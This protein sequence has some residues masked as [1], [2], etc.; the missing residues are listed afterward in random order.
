M[1]GLSHPLRQYLK[2]PDSSGAFFGA[3]LPPPRLHPDS[4]PDSNPAPPLPHPSTGPQ[5]CEPPAGS[6]T[7][8]ERR[9]DLPWQE[10][11]P[12]SIIG[13]TTAGKADAVPCQCIGRRINGSRH[14][15][16][17]RAHAY[18]SHIEGVALPGPQRLG[19]REPAAAITDLPALGVPSRNDALRTERDL[20][21]VGA[22]V[23]D[24]FGGLE[25]R[26]QAD[27]HA[28][29]DGVAVTERLFAGGGVALLGSPLPG[30][31]STR[32]RSGRTLA[33]RAAGRPGRGLG[34][35]SE[36]PTAA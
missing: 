26:M 16:V 7:R 36:W 34:A 18:G 10:G 32:A 9:A 22:L 13:L 23:A 6:A 28:L 24:L 4:N 8:C 25:L 1:K 20:D 2:A 15:N 30:R 11:A 31:S 21:R 12:R 14:R 33:A 19:A 29:I 27:A 3:G 5:R 17:V 35:S